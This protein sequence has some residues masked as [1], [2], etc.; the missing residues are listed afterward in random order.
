MYREASV[1]APWTFVRLVIGGKQPKT[2]K[3][4]AVTGRLPRGPRV[5]VLL[6]N[7]KGKAVLDFKGIPVE[8][9][10][11]VD[12]DKDWGWRMI[13]TVT[14]TATASVISQRPRTTVVSPRKPPESPPWAS[15]WTSSS[16]RP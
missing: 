16:R 11:L 15:P 7:E 12:G 4:R 6:R 14:G 3:Q 5:K 8:Q 10:H 1:S 2:E 9:I 13:G